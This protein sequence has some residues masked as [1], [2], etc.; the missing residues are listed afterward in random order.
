[1]SL[2]PLPRTVLALAALIAACKSERA[3]APAASAPA[4]SASPSTPAPV[5][6][7][8]TDFK[9]DIPAKVPAGAVTMRL[10]NNGKELHQAQIIRLDEGKTMADFQ[11]AMKHEGPPPGWVR[12]VGG[13]NGV[14]PGQET[15]STATLVPGQYVVVCFIPGTDGVP[16][17]MKGMMQPFEVTGGTGPTA[18]A[19]LVAE[20]TVRLADYSFDTSRPLTPGRHTI[21]VENTAAQPHELVLLR[22]APGKTVDDF[23]KWATTGG[24]KGPPPAMPL[25]GVGAMDPGGQGVFTA[26][27]TPGDYGLIC[28]V[29]DAKD[30]KLHLVHGMMKQ[31]K[32]S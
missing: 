13:P 1:M 31:I 18:G 23:G 28:F 29:P 15:T 25:G 17:A 6:V 20:D 16:H 12:F 32:V 14:P 19:L 7:T 4:A 3:P 30:G 9:L 8:A 2:H 27:L 5:T 26:D 11:Q 22:L 24:M 21:L 10:V